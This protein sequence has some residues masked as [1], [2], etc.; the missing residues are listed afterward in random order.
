MLK[1]S[2]ADEQKSD[3]SISAAEFFLA[4]LSSESEESNLAEH[5]DSEKIRSLALVQEGTKLSSDLSWLNQTPPQWKVS[6]EGNTIQDVCWRVW[7]EGLNGYLV[8]KDEERLKVLLFSKGEFHSIRSNIKEEQLL[9]FLLQE[10][11]LTKEQI[12]SVRDVSRASGNPFLWAL[13]AE[14]HLDASEVFLAVKKTQLK[15]MAEL[16]AWQSGECFFYRQEEL[17][18]KPIAIAVSLLDLVRDA[19]QKKL[20]EQSFLLRQVEMDLL[21]SKIIS[22]FLNKLR[23]FLC[24][25]TLKKSKF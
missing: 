23:T 16:F 4:L 3:E 18:N 22:N 13:L 8:C 17:K 15:T 25:L 12:L 2:M 11:V 1:E 21:S 14:E 9:S 20:R 6:L 19:H 24:S 7:Q 5:V 10:N